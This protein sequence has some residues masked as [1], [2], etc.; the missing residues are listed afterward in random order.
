MTESRY[1]GSTAVWALLLAYAS[2]YPFFPLRPPSPEAIAG[3]FL[4]PR[5]IVRSDIAFNVV[6]YVP[7]GTL[8]CLYFRR[9]GEGRHAI[10]KA[11]GFGTAYSLLMEGLQLFVPNRVAT[12][13]DV[14]ANAGGALIG[15]LVFADPLYSVVTKQLG[16]VRERVVI[17]G[18]WG[19]AG[20]VLLMLWLLAQLNPALPFFGAGNIGGEA[21]VE[22]A[23]LHWF[24]VGL[25]ICGF[26]LFVSAL[27][28]AAGALRVTL[29]L[30][31]VA[32]WLKFATASLLLQPHITEDGVSPGRIGGLAGGL[33][34]FVPLRHLP[35]LGRIYLALVM[36]LA[37]ALFAKIF[38]AYSPVEELLRLFRWPHGQLGSFATLT[39]FLH[40]LWP[41]A[42]LVYL[43]SLFFHERRMRQLPG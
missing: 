13:V 15:A 3:F 2:L 29:V 8:A 5:Y 43:I 35:R 36:I 28:Q 24:A 4:T 18:A 26:G 27:M 32:L 9:G 41:V 12:I 7:L 33:L 39:R 14:A 34:L 40:E 31:S 30:L 20:L 17:S 21:R 37:G 23:I 25:A 22:I 38:G 16:E 1:R 19:D 10:V 42:A 6:A 11:I